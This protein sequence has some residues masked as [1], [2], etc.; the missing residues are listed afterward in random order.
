MPTIQTECPDGIA[1]AATLPSYKAVWIAVLVTGLLQGLYA[2]GFIAGTSFV[3]EGHRYFCLFDDAM[4]SMRYAANWAAGH[5]FVWNPGE[6]VEGYTTFGWTFVMGLCHLFR[7]S[8]S[9]TCLL[10]QVLGVPILWGCLAS[11][12]LLARSCKLLPA[13]ACC[14]IVLAGTFYNLI[15]FT[16]FGM[17]TG[18]LTLLVTLALADTVKYISE[19]RGGIRP[20][21]WFA[22]AVLVRLDVLAVMLFVFLFFWFSVKKGRLRLLAGLLV[23]V[24]VVS[25]HFLWRYHFYGQWLPNTYYLK[26]TGWPLL[27]R[28]AAGIRQTF[29]TVVV[30]GLPALLAA[31]AVIEGTKRWRFLILGSF[32]VGVAYQIYIGGDAW[33]WSRFVVPVSLGLFVLA[34]DGIGTVINFC[35]NWTTDAARTVLMVPLTLVCVIAI[36]CVNWDHFLLVARAQSTCDNWMNIKYVLAVERAADPNADVAVA[37]GGVFPYFSNRRC[38]DLLGKCDAYIAHLPA[39]PEVRR[40]GH[41]K[42]DIMYSLEKYRP[43]IV[44][45]ISYK[46]WFPILHKEYH[47]V[48]VEVDGSKMAFCVRNDSTKI[49]GGKPVTWSGFNDCLGAT[50]HERENFQTYLGR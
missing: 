18:L 20:V 31:I 12:A 13:L 34:A 19:K 26:L 4:I 16:L 39:H 32:A 49:R 27:N 9:H 5:G 14:A 3:V 50:I 40:A 6:R 10:V 1:R 17:E 38:I 47:P 11:T 35:K 22:P 41:N 37:F 8:P 21:L 7:L 25:T 36:N 43:D 2:A 45:H 29:W 48:T 30:F 44:L 24:L 23:V 28:I 46:T 15:F 42:Y 33:P